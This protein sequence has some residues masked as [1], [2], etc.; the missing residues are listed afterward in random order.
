MYHRTSLQ[1]K[2]SGLENFGTSTFIW[3]LLSPNKK[4]YKITKSETTL[5]INT[6]DKDSRQSEYMMK[7]N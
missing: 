6:S 5:P 1:S 3:K 4:N 7:Q 2:S